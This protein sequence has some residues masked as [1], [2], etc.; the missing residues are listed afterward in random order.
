MILDCLT[1]GAS[2]G[3]STLHSLRAIDL[4][5]HVVPP[6]LHHALAVRHHLCSL[7]LVRL[8]NH[9][10]KCYHEIEP[11]P[12]CRGPPTRKSIA[13]RH[14]RLDPF[15]YP[16]LNRQRPT[17]LFPKSLGL[18]PTQL[19][20]DLPTGITRSLVAGMYAERL[21]ISP[22]RLAQEPSFKPLS[23]NITS[24][25]SLQTSVEGS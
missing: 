11:S 1:V 3:L 18:T 4:A 15:W 20:C 14:S 7:I 2:H 8:I 16:T 25:T 24:N 5:H 21:E 12:P 23:N 6:F 9:I 10:W 19:Q 22:W 17:L 13:E